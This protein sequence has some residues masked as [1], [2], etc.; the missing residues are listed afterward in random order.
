MQNSGAFTSSSRLSWDFHHFQETIEHIHVLSRDRY[1]MHMSHHIKYSPA[2]RLAAGEEIGIFLSNYVFIKG[3]VVVQRHMYS[4]LSHPCFHSK[5]SWR[6]E[7]KEKAL[8]FSHHPVCDVIFLFMR[9]LCCFSIPSNVWALNSHEFSPF[10]WMS[11]CCWKRKSNFFSSSSDSLN[12]LTNDE[13][14]RQIE[15]LRAFL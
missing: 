8:G 10:Y 12:I 6:S 1:N 5:L 14:I 2:D 9:Q 15:R 4:F 3:T 13:K 7:E 11:G